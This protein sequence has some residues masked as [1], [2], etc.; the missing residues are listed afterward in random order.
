MKIY[1][2]QTNKELRTD[3]NLKMMGISTDDLNTLHALGWYEYISNYPEYNKIIQT[4]EKDG[5]P[6]FSNNQYVQ[7]YRVVSLPAERIEELREQLF[8]DLRTE[9]NRRLDLTD[10]LVLDYPLSEEQLIEV[11]AYRQALRDLPNQSD[12]PFW[13][14]IPWPVAPEFLS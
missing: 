9:R 12:A 3:L 7:S 14:E 1:I 13:E 5:E 4:L 8:K 2:N 11:K 6:V 10:Y